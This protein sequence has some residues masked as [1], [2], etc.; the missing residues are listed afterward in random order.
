MKQTEE[1]RIGDCLA[2]TRKTSPIVQ[3]ITNFVTVN[4]CAN[5]ILAAGGSPTMAKHPGEAAE[6]Q[7]GCNALVLNM[8]TVDS[9]EAMIL[10][11]QKAN[12][13]GHPVVFD[14]VGAGASAL[15][16]DTAAQLLSRIRMTAVRGNASEIRYLAEGTGGQAGGVD[17]AL[18]DR[19]TKENVL[20]WAAL[21][22][23]LAKRLD[24]IVCISGTLDVM[25]D[26]RQAFAFDG[27]N[28]LMS[29]ITGSGCML[30]SLMG[31]IFGANTDRTLSAAI[32]AQTLMNAAGDIAF[33]KTQAAGGG[34]M[35]FRMHLIDAVSLMDEETLKR[36]ARY[37]ELPLRDL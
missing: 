18:S 30:T 36:Y 35:T 24:A 34:T 3:C 20:R 31:A 8:G 16:R 28:V 27:G 29:R 5:I 4:D 2:R 22:Q 15:R 9:V 6:I 19:V 32:C 25:T 12:E 21:A 7:A 13:L 17:A 37:H 26:G 10:A 33:E 23:G 11:G 14:P 1:R